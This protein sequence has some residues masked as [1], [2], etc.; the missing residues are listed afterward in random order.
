MAREL[1]CSIHHV[2]QLKICARI[3]ISPLLRRLFCEPTPRTLAIYVLLVADPWLCPVKLP[4][5]SALRVIFPSSPLLPASLI[6]SWPSESSHVVIN[7]RVELPR[8]ARNPCSVLDTLSF[9]PTIIYSRTFSRRWLR[10]TQLMHDDPSSIYLKPVRS[11]AH[12]RHK[13]PRQL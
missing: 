1:Y 11:C 3:A 5:C 7:S 4:I 6:C 13:L 9:R 12:L 8:L 10:T 2:S